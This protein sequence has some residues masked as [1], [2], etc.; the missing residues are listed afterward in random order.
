MSHRRNEGTGAGTGREGGGA[1]DNSNTASK[2]APSDM[3][4][5]GWHGLFGI[6]G[7]VAAVPQFVGVDKSVCHA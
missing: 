6:I 2:A 7:A 5:P 4:R 1:A 3:P